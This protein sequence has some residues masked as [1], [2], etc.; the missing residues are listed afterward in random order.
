[1][2]PES[3]AGEEQG[4]AGQASISS[5]SDHSRPAPRVSLI[6]TAAFLTCLA[7][8]GATT[9]GSE[10]TGKAAGPAHQAQAWASSVLIS[11]PTW[12]ELLYDSV[13]PS[14]QWG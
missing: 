10:E 13:S 14:V 9:E 6:G 8:E 5:A 4:R 1:M 7:L 11:T 12:A 3:A 2:S